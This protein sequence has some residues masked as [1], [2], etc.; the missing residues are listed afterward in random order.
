M[1]GAQCV[2]SFIVCSATFASAMAMFAALK[3]VG[4]LRVTEEDEIE[5]LD[6]DQHG[7]TAYPEYVIS[8]RSAG[9]AMGSDGEVSTRMPASQVAT[10]E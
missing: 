7:N 8:T 2:G 4:L 10:A 6:L 5:G 3:A 9:H 1:L